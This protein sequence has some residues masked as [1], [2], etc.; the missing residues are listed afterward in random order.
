M[1]ESPIRAACILGATATGKTRLAAR[2]AAGA[3]GEVISIDSRQV[4]RG[5]DLGTGKDL[6]EYEVGGRAIPFHLIDIADPGDEYH[7]FQFKCDCVTA[8]REIHHRQHLPVLCGGSGLYLSAILEDYQLLSAPP[9]PVRRAEWEATSTESLVER[10]RSHGALHNTTDTLDRKRL[11][12]ALEVSEA[13]P[14]SRAPSVKLNTVIF[15]IR[16]ERPKL[17]QRITRRLEERLEQGM[18]DEPRALLAAGLKPEQ[19]T[20]YGLEYRFLTQH[21]QGEQSWQEMFDG[22]NAAIHQFAKR[23]ETWFRR[24]ER[25]GVEIE[26]LDGLQS[27]EANVA[28]MLDRLRGG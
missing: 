5:M 17:R 20:F 7:L 28:H 8:I 22:L 11:I 19:L 4:Y 21:L 1:S 13:D 2:L 18:L 16:I 10:L 24:M 23:Q 26:W 9:D 3:N 6:E 27:P 12:R 15:G 25:Q 14:S